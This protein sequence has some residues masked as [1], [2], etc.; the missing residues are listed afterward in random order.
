MPMFLRQLYRFPTF[1][2]MAV[3]FA[4]LQFLSGLLRAYGIR[5]RLQHYYYHCTAHLLRLHISVEGTLA[6]PPALTIANHCSYVDVMLLGTLGDIRF[7]PKDEVRRWPILGQMAK[8][9][10]VIFVSRSRSESKNTHNALLDALQSGKRLCVFAEGTT[11]NGRTLKPFKASVFHLAEQWRG[12]APLTVQPLV[13][14]YDGVDGKAM[15]DVQWDIVAWYGDDTLI[16]HLWRLCGVREIRATILCL[17]PLS[18]AE[19]ET[20][21]H[22]SERTRNAIFSHL[23]HME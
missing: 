17:P 15:G 7:T 14:R 19:G 20:R 10:D 18:L 13:V 21:K 23:P 5:R 9:F 4:L 12:E 11:S 3:M 6:A 8:A 1:L 16:R 22:L 2:I